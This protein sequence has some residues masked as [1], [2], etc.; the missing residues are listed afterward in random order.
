ME[1][2]SGIYRITQEHTGQVYVGSSVDIE[3]RWKQHEMWLSGEVEIAIK[4]RDG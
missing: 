4:P 2:K 3:K 1:I